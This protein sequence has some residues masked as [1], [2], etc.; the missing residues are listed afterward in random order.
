MAM[1]RTSATWFTMTGRA[2]AV[3]PWMLEAITAFS[4][5]YNETVMLMC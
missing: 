3:L 1:E 2:L 4:G 5:F